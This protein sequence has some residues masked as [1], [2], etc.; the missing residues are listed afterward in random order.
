MEKIG[1]KGQSKAKVFDS[2]DEMLKSKLKLINQKLK[3]N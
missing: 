1:T 3:T 2:E